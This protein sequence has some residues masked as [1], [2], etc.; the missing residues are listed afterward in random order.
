M[1]GAPTEKALMQGPTING[2]GIKQTR[3]WAQPGGRWG[4]MLKRSM[5]SGQVWI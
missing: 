1:I 3:T 4:Q 5:N 2:V